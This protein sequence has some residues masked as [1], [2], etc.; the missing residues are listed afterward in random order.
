[1]MTSPS[2]IISGLRFRLEHGNAVLPWRAHPG[3]AGIDLQYQ[4][5]NGVDPFVSG[6]FSTEMVPT[7]VS[8]SIPA[9]YVGMIVPRSGM[10]LKTGLRIANSPGIIDSGFRGEIHVLLWHCDFEPWRLMPGDRIVQLVIAPIALPDVTEWLGAW[11]ETERGEDGFGS[12]G[13]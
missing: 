10:S 5:W 11:D 4:P 12:T 7:G 1:M 13:K 2:E 8:V 3:D 9:P 6:G